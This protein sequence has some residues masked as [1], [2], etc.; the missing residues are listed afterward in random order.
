MNELTFMSRL[1]VALSA[2]PGVRVHRQNVGSI[3]QRDA[4]GRKR[5][6]FHAGPPVGAADITGGVGPEGWRLEVEVKSASGERSPEQLAWAALCARQGYVYALVQYDDALEPDAN[7][8]AGAALVASA[9]AAKREA[10]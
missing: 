6:V 5:S 1:M 4:L 8:A 10:R 3:V 2:M 7:V 9:I